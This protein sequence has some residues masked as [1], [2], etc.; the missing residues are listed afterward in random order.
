MSGTWIEPAHSLLKVGAVALAWQLVLAAL[1]P[2]SHWRSGH[3]VARRA[4]PSTALCA[5][6]ACAP[7]SPFTFLAAREAPGVVA[8]LLER[9][10]RCKDDRLP[11]HDA[12]AAA[13]GRRAGEQSGWES[14]RDGLVIAG[15]C[16]LL[17]CVG[18]APEWGTPCLLP[19]GSMFGEDID[20][21][22]VC[23]LLSELGCGSIASAVPSTLG[24]ARNGA[25]SC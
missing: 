3:A 1:D 10:A 22:L 5:V 13:R 15:R 20:D 11:W 21:F 7:R 12:A 9:T 4:A 16:M 6:Q 18:E 25:L 17:V 14:E 2:N 24:L 8:C 19:G 23:V